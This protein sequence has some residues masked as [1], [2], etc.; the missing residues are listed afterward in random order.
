MAAAR[1]IIQTSK[2]HSNRR[3]ANAGIFLDLFREYKMA[4]SSGEKAKR[5]LIDH[6][7]FNAYAAVVLLYVSRHFP[8]WKKWIL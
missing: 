5:F 7:C 3:S 6:L 4:K 8:Q 1:V 2:Y